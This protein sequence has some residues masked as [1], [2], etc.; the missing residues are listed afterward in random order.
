MSNLRQSE[1]A[2]VGTQILM[3]EKDLWAKC[4]FCRP[5]VKQKPINRTCSCSQYF[6]NKNENWN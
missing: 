6:V 3:A 4:M 2:L 1:K 5:Q